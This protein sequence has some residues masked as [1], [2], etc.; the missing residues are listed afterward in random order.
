MSDF[1][2]VKMLVPSSNATLQS[3]AYP[4]LCVEKSLKLKLGLSTLSFATCSWC[5]RHDVVSVGEPGVIRTMQSA[6]TKYTMFYVRDAIAYTTLTV[7]R[8]T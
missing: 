3:R 1:T 6:V 4:E 7:A 5:L 2:D 8:T